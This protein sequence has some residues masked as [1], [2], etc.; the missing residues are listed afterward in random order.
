MR[1]RLATQAPT[2]PKVSAS[3]N[4]VFRPANQTVHGATV[5]AKHSPELKRSVGTNSMITAMAR[6]T[7]KIWV[8]VPVTLAK[9]NLA[10]VVPKEP[11]EQV[12]VKKAHKPATATAHGAPVKEKCYQAQKR[13]V[14]TNSM[15]TVMAKLTPQ[16]Q[17]FAN[18]IHKRHAPATPAPKAQKMLV[19][20]KK[21]HRPVKPM[22]NGTFAS[23]TSHH[24]MRP[25]MASMKIV[26][27][28]S[29]MSPQ[30]KICVQQESVASEENVFVMR[31]LVRR[32][33][34]TQVETVS[35]LPPT[36]SVVQMA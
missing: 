8:P 11:L 9:H 22:V 34:V 29:T 13:S 35:Q 20:V 33:V 27:E 23:P 12:S 6:L 1:A 5:K 2:T 18:V 16:T 17:L 15:T 14:E 32:V 31:L 21:A 28:T 19:P 36:A 26:T 3:A 7:P 10:T 30:D 24:K 25:V 4:K